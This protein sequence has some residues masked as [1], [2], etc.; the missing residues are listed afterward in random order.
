MKKLFAIV[1]ASLCI[2]CFASSF[3]H[4]QELKIGVFDIQ[5]IMKES[6][7][8]SD[9]RQDFLKGIEL[10]RKPLLDKEAFVK[11]IEEKVKKDGSSLSPSDRKAIEEKLANEI[12]EARRMKE[13]FDTEAAKMERNLT[14]KIFSE[15][16]AIVRKIDEKENYTIIFEKSAAGIVLLKNTVDITDK[17]LGQ[18][19]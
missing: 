12:K 14:Q 19:K 5:R 3:I 6:K 13:D 11:A 2:V 18:L 10:K 9:Y 8:V 7:T 17:I 16:D 1:F 15:L 4:A